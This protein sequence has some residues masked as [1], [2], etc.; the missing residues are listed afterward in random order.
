M[1]CFFPEKGHSPYN[2]SNTDTCRDNVNL[3][4]ELKSMLQYSVDDLTRFFCMDE[5]HIR[6]RMI[7]MSN[8]QPAGIWTCRYFCHKIDPSIRC[9]ATADSIP[10]FSSRHFRTF[11]VPHAAVEILENPPPFQAF[12]FSPYSDHIVGR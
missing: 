1:V 2:C 3:E 11:H 4:V 7:A 12:H 10:L 5:L 8:F 6:Y 9:Y